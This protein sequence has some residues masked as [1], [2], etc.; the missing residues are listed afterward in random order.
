MT[1]TDLYTDV[2][3]NI[4]TAI[5]NGLANDR[6]ELPWHGFSDM[7]QN[8]TTKKIYRGVNVPLLWVFQMERGYKSGLWA[9][10]NQ[11]HECGAQVRKGEKG[12]P[13]V[14]WKS[15]EVDEENSADEQ[16]TRMFARYSTV[17]NSDQ[18]DGFELITQE[19][20]AEIILKDDCT[21]FV[22]STGALIEHGHPY[23][24]YRPSD[25]KIYMPQTDIFRAT[26][27]NTA[28]ENY[29]STLFHELT[30]WTGAGFRLDRLAK[31]GFGKADYA[32]EELVAELGAAMLCAGLG[33]TPCPRPDHA[34][35]IKSWLKALGND[36]RFIFSAASQAQKAVDYLHSLQT[37]QAV[38]A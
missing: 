33:A 34:Q 17:F 30:H 2:T 29:Y 8:A 18:V 9:T 28:T 27:N 19:K 23:A 12:A 15:V 21:H 14:F 5:E 4:A 7:P 25:D 13:I 11:W 36:T 24:C 10:Y 35:Y 6:W 22:N 3:N 20:R 31:E 16:K 1:R 37:A 26:G 38:A 32:F